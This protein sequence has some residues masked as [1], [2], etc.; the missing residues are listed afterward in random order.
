M[1]T[2]TPKQYLQ[3]GDKSVIE[4]ALESLFASPV[5][6]GI[7]VA[8]SPDDAWWEQLA[9]SFDRPLIAVTGGRERSESVLNALQAIQPRVSFDDW[10]LVHDAARPCLRSQD[11]DLLLHVAGNDATGGLLAVPVRDTMKQGDD[12]ARVS[13]TVDRNALWHALT[14]QMFRYGSLVEALEVTR[15]NGV[16]ITD[17]A[18]AIEY[19]G[20]S[21]K[22]VEG[23]GDNIKI[24]RSE[25]LALAEFYLRQQGRL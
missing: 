10:V 20:H 12:D 9:L 4:H 16:S 19:M 11:L 3:L 22:L 23:H 13:S 7:A 24:T 15:R 14:P 1:G 21:P 25:D 8:V 18:S 17:E 6:Q 5:I 2:D